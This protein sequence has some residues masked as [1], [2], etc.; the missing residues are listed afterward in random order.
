MSKNAFTPRVAIIGA[1][2]GG[3]AMAVY[4]DRAGIRDFTV[5]EKSGGPG[6]VWWN[7]TY[8][9]AEV[10]TPSHMYSFS[11]SRY[12]WSGTHASQEELQQYI[13]DTIDDFGIRDRIRFNTVVATATW[14]DVRSQYLVTL[15]N[16]EE[17]WFD[18]VVSATGLL[19]IPMI[20]S[21]IDLTRFTGKVFHTSCWDHTYDF[22]GAKVAVVGT[23][24]TSVQIVPALAEMADHLYVFQREPGWILP[25]K[26]RIFTEED[27]SRTAVPWRYRIERAKAYTLRHRSRGPAAF[28]EGTK[29][30]LAG[31]DECLAF[32]EQELADR[33][34]LKELLTPKY[35]FGGKRAVQAKPDYY[36]ALKR[37]NVTL[38]P[39]AVRGAH[40]RVVE[41]VDG[42]EF[43]VDAIILA[44]GFRTTD[45]LSSFTLTGREGTPQEYWQGEPAAYLGITVPTFPNFFMM[46][47]PNTNGMGLM[48]MLERQADFIL[49]SIKQSMRRGGSPVEVKRA[50]YDRY[51]RWVD[52]R[53]ANTVWTK[54]NNYFKTPSGRIVTQFPEGLPLYWALTKFL[55]RGAHT[56]LERK[57]GALEK[58]DEP[59]AME[60]SITRSRA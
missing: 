59:R 35:P 30:N 13:E 9:G 7:N 37:P 16:G 51:N 43:E 40:G 54:A 47:G 39:K 22:G 19:S 5:F 46:Y 12:P 24:S 18:F 32:I 49:R 28:R 29:S 8:P 21:Q 58:E 33:P 26:S 23:G 53:M 52:R 45:F 60:R 42:A 50:A 44:T 55:R 1:G 4:L 6:G 31:R 48:F 25:K 57:A 17:Q 14:D 38:V 11:F 3:T 36:R 15:A 10:D 2:L 34:D 41:T 27:R 20:P 56:F